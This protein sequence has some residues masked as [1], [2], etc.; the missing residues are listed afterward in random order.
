MVSTGIM[1]KQIDEATKEAENICDALSVVHDTGTLAGQDSKVIVTDVIST[2]SLT[3]YTDDVASI[4][5]P[6]I[7]LLK[8]AKV[9]G[10]EDGLNALQKC[11]DWL[12][13]ADP[14]KAA[15]GR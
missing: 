3:P 1:Q 6:K 13:D 10:T 8:G 9:E 14:S 4:L 15:Q 11:T 7:E 2:M 12:S 5:R